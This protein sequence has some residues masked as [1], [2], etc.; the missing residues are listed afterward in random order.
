MNPSSVLNA[1]GINPFGVCGVKDEMVLQ[2]CDWLN[3]NYCGYHI[4]HLTGIIPY[5]TSFFRTPNPKGLNP[6]KIEQRSM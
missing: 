1:L 5:Q 4:L 3:K 6:I 2:F